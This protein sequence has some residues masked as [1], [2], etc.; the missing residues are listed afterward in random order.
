M[1]TILGLPAHPLI[2][3]AVVVL[4]P[5]SALGVLL[6]A[7]VPRWRP[8]FG[9]LVL[10][11]TALAT[12][13]VPLA[14]ESG[15]SLQRQVESSDL[16]RKHTD[17]GDTMLVFALPLLAMAVALWWLGRQEKRHVAVG[18]GVVLTITVLSVLAS[19]AAGVQILRIGHSGAESVWSDVGAA[20]SS[21]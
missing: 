6:L 4:V 20:S 21:T 14:T 12:A 8:T 3:H 2:V 19:A 9:P 11:V 17:L 7:L 15:E 1:D 18:R 10:V 16:L 5:L 13:M